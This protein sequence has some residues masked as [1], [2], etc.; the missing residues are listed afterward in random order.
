MKPAHV[1]FPF[2]LDTAAHLVP[3]ARRAGAP[4]VPPDLRCTLIDFDRAQGGAGVL[5]GCFG[6]V[7][8]HGYLAPETVGAGSPRSP[9]VEGESGT[10]QDV[11]AFGATLAEL[12]LGRPI[13]N[14]DADTSAQGRFRAGRARRVRHFEGRL[15]HH[16]AFCNWSDDVALESLLQAQHEAS[17]GKLCM[18]IPKHAAVVLSAG[19][20]TTEIHFCTSKT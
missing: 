15:G 3:S 2:P 6:A 14:S 13:F 8:T 17:A 20:W 11:W 16:A 9:E 4:E 18:K 7:G 5:T 10:A 12:A 1:L 19:F